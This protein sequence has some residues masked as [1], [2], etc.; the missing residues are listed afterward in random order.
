MVAATSAG[1]VRVA[2]S[3]LHDYATRHDGLQIFP[4]QRFGRTSRAA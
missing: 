2:G 1:S 3:R 4:L